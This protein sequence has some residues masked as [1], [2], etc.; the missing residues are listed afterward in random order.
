MVTLKNEVVKWYLSSNETP[1]W[2]A[3]LKEHQKAN[4]NKGETFFIS[5]SYQISQN[6]VRKPLSYTI[7]EGAARLKSCR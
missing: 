1:V 2:Q 3:H 7:T 5:V 4:L 6:C